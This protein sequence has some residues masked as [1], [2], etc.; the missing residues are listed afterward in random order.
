MARAA[1]VELTQGSCSVVIEYVRARGVLRLTGNAGSRVGWGPIEV[2]FVDLVGRLR[3][4]LSV[5][6]PE[7]PFLLF[8][9]DR[10]LGGSKD[11]VGAFSSEVAARSQFLELRKGTTSWAEVVTLS[12]GKLRQVC[13]FGSPDEAPLRQR[14]WR[15]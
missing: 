10:T 5:L 7:Q 8:A 6:V 9:G 14:R 2:T 4:D 3:V 11:F 15:R 1:S 12:Q 13:W